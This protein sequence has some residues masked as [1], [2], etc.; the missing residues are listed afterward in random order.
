VAG[1]LR[2]S[3][4]RLLKRKAA[5]GVAAIQLTSDLSIHRLMLD[6]VAAF[7]G[8]IIDDD[9]WCVCHNC[10]LTSASLFYLVVLFSSFCIII[11]SK[12]SP[13]PECIAISDTVTKW[14]ANRQDSASLC[15]WEDHLLAWSQVRLEGHLRG[16]RLW[17]NLLVSL[18]SGDPSSTTSELMDWHS[19]QPLPVATVESD[20][21][22]WPGWG[23]SNSRLSC[24]FR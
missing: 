14:L 9:D 20:M 4:G 15:C 23:M 12:G 8:H 13:I 19:R 18:T 11:L 16:H 10:G 1:N 5:E 3:K 6:D 17:T 2:G 7:A 24:S 22:D 21:P